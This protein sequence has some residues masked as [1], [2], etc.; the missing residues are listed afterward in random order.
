MMHLSSPRST[1][2]VDSVTIFSNLC[3]ANQY[4]VIFMFYWCLCYD[5]LIGLHS[6]TFCESD[7]LKKRMPF[8][9]NLRDAS[10]HHKLRCV[11]HRKQMYMQD[12][13]EINRYRR[14]FCLILVSATICTYGTSQSMIKVASLSCRSGQLVWYPRPKQVGNPQGHAKGFGIGSLYGCQPPHHYI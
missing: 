1:L 11:M 12:L 3:S 8:I 13:M 2:W 6:T 9:P 7:R 5:L 4:V 10:T 14:S